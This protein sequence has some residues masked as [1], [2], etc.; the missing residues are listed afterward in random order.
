MTATTIRPKAAKLH[1]AA[2]Y[3]DCP[4]CGAE[5][6]ND[7]GSLMFDTADHRFTG[8]VQPCQSCGEPIRFPKK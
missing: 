3:V 2:W 7:D 4:H 1:L 6:S 5:Q 8:V